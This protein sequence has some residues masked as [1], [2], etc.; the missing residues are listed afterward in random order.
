MTLSSLNRH[1]VATRAD[2]G[3]PKATVLANHF[4][5]I[6]PEVN[7]EPVVAM[8][9]HA[10]EEQVLGGHAP[11]MVIDA[12]DNLDTKVQFDLSIA[13]GLCTTGLTCVGGCRQN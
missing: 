1:A 4:H 10:T 3:L 6:F 12:I 8:Y 7:V 2:V 5:K 13:P 9:T 11:D